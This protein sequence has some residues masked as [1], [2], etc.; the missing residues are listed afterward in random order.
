MMLSTQRIER[1]RERERK[2]HKEREAGRG[3]TQKGTILI[4]GY[5]STKRLRT[6]ALWDQ[7]W[8][9]PK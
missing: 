9:G 2:R 4:W 6:P 3:G 7:I 5:A 8:S 1:E